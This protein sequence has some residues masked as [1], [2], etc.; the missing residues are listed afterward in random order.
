MGYRHNEEGFPLLVASKNGHDV[1]T[2]DLPHRHVDNGV[3]A[4]RGGILPPCRVEKWLRCG[5]EGFPLIVTSIME[6]RC[7]KKGFPLLVASKNG[8]DV[9][10][11][12]SPSL[13]RRH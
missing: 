5:D 13:P 11:R 9:A 12:D 6:F 10:T 2:R 7:N 8:C 3:S 1:A 4:R